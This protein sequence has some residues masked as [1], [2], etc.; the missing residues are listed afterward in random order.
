M[1][2][3]AANVVDVIYQYFPSSIDKLDPDRGLFPGPKPKLLLVNSF[4]QLTMMLLGHQRTDTKIEFGAQQV[5]LV[6]DDDA[7]NRR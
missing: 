5:V 7:R 1:L 4:N 2:Q 3:L 6:R